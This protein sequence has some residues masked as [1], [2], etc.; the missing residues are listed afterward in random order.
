M[1]I[2]FRILSDGLLLIIPININGGQMGEWCCMYIHE[3]DDSPEYSTDHVPTNETSW[4]DDLS[5]DELSILNQN[6]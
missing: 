4:H 2:R 3:F 6:N 5:N 1:A